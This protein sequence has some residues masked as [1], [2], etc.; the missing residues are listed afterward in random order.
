MPEN[1]AT[2]M[3]WRISAPAPVEKTSGT[4]PM[5]KASE[6]I[7]IG[8]SRSRLAS[9][10]ACTG[11]RP[12]NSSSRANST[13]RMAFLADSP[14]STIRPIWV[15]MLLSPCVSNTPAM[16]ASSAHRHDHDDRQRQHQALVERGQHQEHQQDREREDQD[17]GVAGQDLLVGQLGPFEADALRQRLGGDALDRR[18][19]LAGGVAG[20]RRRR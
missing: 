20:R 19:G 4:T 2:P 6:V 12:A 15:K 16:A 18:L 9:I 14:T 17:G 13:I 3:A 10:A 7:R 1:T 5:M 11:V 8:R